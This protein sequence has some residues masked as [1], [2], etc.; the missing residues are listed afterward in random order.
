MKESNKTIYIV[1][2]QTG[3]VLSR[4]LKVLTHAKY[5]HASISLERDLSVMYSFGRVHPYNPLLGGF[6]RESVRYGTFKRFSGTEAVVLSMDIADETYCHMLSDVEQMYR[7]KK[8]YH[9]NYVGLY[10][11]AFGIEL[12][13]KRWFYC[14]EFVK[15]MLLK[16]GLVKKETL[17]GITKP[18]DFLKIPNTQVVYRGKLKNYC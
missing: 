3:T 17:Q 18:M 12:R 8:R 14:S 15:Y 7:Q 1:V 16:Y 5:N 9:Y 2:S 4:I 10:A 13:H 11:A 6:V